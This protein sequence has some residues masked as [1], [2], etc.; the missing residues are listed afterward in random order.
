MMADLARKALAQVRG[1]VIAILTTGGMDRPHAGALAE[2]L[3]TGT[4]TQDYPDY[5][6]AGQGAGPAGERR[7]P[8]RGA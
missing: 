3:A 4:V 5:I 7:I 6:R 2:T 8:Q 1:A